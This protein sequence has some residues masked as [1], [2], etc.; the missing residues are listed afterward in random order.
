M[1]QMVSAEIHAD[2]FVRPLP[3]R[4]PK[5]ARTRR[6]I[7]DLAARL[8]IERGYG[9]VSLRDIAEAA[10]ITK[11]AIYGHF[12]SKG[13]L[14]VEVVRWKTDEFDQSPGFNEAARDLEH[15]V[16]LI[17]DA[18]TRDLR[19]LEVDAAVAA[20][21]DPDVAA[22]LAVHYRQRQEMIREMMT[23]ARDPDAAAWLVAVLTAGIGTKESAGIPMPAADALHSTLVAIVGALLEDTSGAAAHSPG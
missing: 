19:L 11:G 18:R 21:H 6:R 5:S 8:F 16:D 13:Q 12:R 1:S 3:P 15:G 9:A 17:Y 23:D 4:T 7:L 10:E 14:L 20:R 2:E 22:G